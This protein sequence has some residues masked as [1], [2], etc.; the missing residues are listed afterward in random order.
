M[1]R[2]KHESERIG[3]VLDVIRSVAEQT[4]L[5]AL[6][7]A[8]EAARAGDAGRGF[9]VVADEVRNLAK[10][11]QDATLEIQ[12]LI[13]GLQAIAD[14]SAS[15]MDTCR[16]LTDQTVEG[17][18]STGAA[19]QDISRMIASIQQMMQQI[20][21]AAEQQSAVAEEINLS[22]IRVRE[23]S[24]RSAVSGELSAKACVDLAELGSDLQ[25]KVGRFR[26]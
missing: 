25:N 7:A 10:R 6:N 26:I 4:N 15:T 5:L 17:V 3:G 19:V 24:E 20:A 21:T 18:D 9:A 11:T 14:E 8:I 22:V 1:M 23:I 12:V 2:L 13:Q 16:N